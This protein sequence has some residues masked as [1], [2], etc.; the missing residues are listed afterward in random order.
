MLRA[1]FLFRCTLRSS[2]ECKKW[3][4]PASPATRKLAADVNGPLMQELIDEIQF[5]DPTC[6]EMFRHGACCFQHVVLVDFVCVRIQVPTFMTR[7]PI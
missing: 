7:T 1:C 5:A 3:L 4:A 2:G 6:V